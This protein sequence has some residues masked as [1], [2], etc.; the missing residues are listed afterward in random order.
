VPGNAQKQLQAAIQKQLGLVV[1]R[2]QQD[3]DV[4]LI[5]LRRAGAPGLKAS[6]GAGKRSRSGSSSGKFSAENSPISALASH[7]EQSLKRLVIDQTGLNGRYNFT[8]DDRVLQSGPELERTLLDEF[9]LE[10]VPGRE[11]VEMLVVEKAP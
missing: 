1:R 5:K 4:L 10:L 3:Q 7:L 6:V 9:G 11:P 2:E 8:F